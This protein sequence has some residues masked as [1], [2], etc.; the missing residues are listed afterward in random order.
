VKRLIVYVCL[1]VPLCAADGPQLLWHA[2]RE[3]TIQDWICGPGGCDRTPAPPFH[4]LKDD[5]G[6][7]SP[8]ISVSDAKGRQWSVKFGAEVIPE[9]FGARFVSALGYFAEPS[10]YVQSGRIDLGYKVHRARR[11]V[12]RDGRFERAR[13]QLRGQK[14]MEFLQ[15]RAWAWDENPFRGTRE[16]AGLKIVMMLLSNWDA[17]DS[18]DG[19]E[20]NNNVFRGTVGGREYL[21]YSVYD[22]GASLGRW[23]NVLRRDQSDCPSFVED[24]PHFV[25]GVRAGEIEWGFDGKHGDDLRK[26]I[27]VADVRWL[28]PHLRRITPEQLQAG[29]K[30]SGATERQAGCWAGAIG[31][32]IRQLS[33]VAK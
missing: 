29:L 2:P 16:L 10:Y 20:S 32:R 13:F 9:C 3:M 22:W 7:T 6:G 23:G 19:S 4:F 14:D 31:E 5:S 33:D 17:K 24:S 25:K 30:A 21:M 27:T 15:G 18:R 12:R 1:A 28:L 26:G 11:V 8:K